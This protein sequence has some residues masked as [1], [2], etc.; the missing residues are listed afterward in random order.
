MLNL[1]LLD[2]N[3]TLSD[4]N[5]SLKDSKLSFDGAYYRLQRDRQL[6]ENSLQSQ[7]NVVNYF[8][9]K[10][11]KLSDAMDEIRHSTDKALEDLKPL[12]DVNHRLMVS[13]DTLVSQSCLCDAIFQDE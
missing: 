2:E 3:R 1:P 4:V 10:L 13:C 9:S 6:L 7:K 8:A 11:K 5:S 12:Q